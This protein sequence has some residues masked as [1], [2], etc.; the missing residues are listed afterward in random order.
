MNKRYH[1]VTGLVLFSTILGLVLP[2]SINIS[3]RPLTTDVSVKADDVNTDDT[4]T[5]NINDAR[6]KLNQLSADFE[7]DAQVNLSGTDAD[8][9]TALKN[10]FDTNTE[11]STSSNKLETEISNYTNGASDDATFLNNIGYIFTDLNDRALPV[12]W[13]AFSQVFAEA[14]QQ[15]EQEISAAGLTDNAKATQFANTVKA[16]AD[17]IYLSKSTAT[18]TKLASSGGLLANCISKGVDGIN[19]ASSGTPDSRQLADAEMILEEVV[20]ARKTMIN[21]LK[22]VSDQSKNAALTKIDDAMASD[23]A[24]IQA[25]KTSGAL[26]TVVVNFVKEYMGIIPVSD[27]NV[28]SDAAKKATLATLDTNYQQTIGKLSA[29]K[30]YDTDVKVARSKADELYAKYKNQIAAAVTSSDLTAIT[31]ESSWA[32][33]ATT[34]LM[35]TDTEK[36]AAIKIINDAATAQ[37][38]IINADSQASDTEKATAITAVEN[39]VKQYTGKIQASNTTVQ[40]ITTAQTGALTT[41]K[42]T[43]PMH[44]LQI[45]TAQRNAAINAV[46]TAGNTEK[47]A[48]QNDASIAASDKVAAYAAVDKLVTT[49][50][51]QLKA[52]KSATDLAK[53]QNTGVAAVTAYQVAKTATVTATDP[54]TSSVA[55]PSVAKASTKKVLYAI[56]G[57]KLYKSDSLKGKTVASYAKHKR[58]NRPT[59]LVTKTVKNDAGKKVYYVQNQASGKK[60]YITSSTKSVAYAYY[61]T[62]PKKVQV[63]SK[64]GVNQYK[65]A[66]LSTKQK[67]YKKGQTLKVKKLI[68]SGVTTRFQLTNGSY[69]SANKKFVIDTQY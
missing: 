53:I 13:E 10:Q 59:F 42:S 67:H 37:K 29:I 55:A 22:S 32:L 35:A 9:I 45:T 39:W 54:T 14:Y 7:A 60:G 40:D 26:R 47:V 21:N 69:I 11:A 16:Y 44:S 20:N 30:G 63:I 50:T 49:Y 52:A 48:I 68:K 36:A 3:H 2:G 5:Q 64:G 56:S 51:D 8:T 58:T 41:I 31:N 4:K 15:R 17:P 65:K 23:K 6:N 33:A 27:V 57:L 24:K 66:N 43:T 34:E 46:I 19:I 18:K 12:D 25:A 38:A 62:T 1:V 61:Q 28:V